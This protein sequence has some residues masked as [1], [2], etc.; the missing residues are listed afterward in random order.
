[1]VVA[2]TRRIQTGEL[3]PDVSNHELAE[4]ILSGEPR[5]P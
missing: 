5:A 3:K 2:M 4:M 1:M